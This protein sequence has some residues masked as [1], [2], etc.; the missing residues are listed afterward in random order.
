MSPSPSHAQSSSS[1]SSSTS[2][3]NRSPN[4]SRTPLR[5]LPAPPLLASNMG[6]EELTLK[7]TRLGHERRPARLNQNEDDMGRDH[8]EGRDSREGERLGF[9]S[10]SS[11]PNF[12]PVLPPRSGSSGGTGYGQGQ[13]QGQGH[14]RGSEQETTIR[15]ALGN[16]TLREM[17]SGGTHLTRQTPAPLR[18]P[19]ASPPISPAPSTSSR[20]SRGSDFQENDRDQREEAY[21]GRDNSGN[22]L[23]SAGPEERYELL[24]KLGAGNFGV[25]WKA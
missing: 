23:Y 17:Y 19:Y 2:S 24:S 25:V 9:R 4:P 12:V 21:Y 10:P 5:S 16:D 8:L 6:P 1:S 3:P 13:G 18:D 15:S 22:S 7:P 11:E 14:S 20:S